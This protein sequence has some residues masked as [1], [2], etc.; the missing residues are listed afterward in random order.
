MTAMST[1][2]RSGAAR[3]RGLSA[4]THPRGWKADVRYVPSSENRSHGSSMG[5]KLRRF[6][7]GV[8]FR[9]AFSTR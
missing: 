3:A 6:C 4:A 9:Y 2:R 7:N 5:A 8:R 1:R